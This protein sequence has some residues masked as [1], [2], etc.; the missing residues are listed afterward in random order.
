MILYYNI[1]KYFIILGFLFSEVFNLGEEYREMYR[2][3]VSQ[4]YTDIRAA[5]VNSDNEHS[6]AVKKQKLDDFEKK[7]E[8]IIFIRSNYNNSEYTLIV[9]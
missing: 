4:G 5:T 9:S 2:F 3:Y 7:C 8:N 1:Y 6:P